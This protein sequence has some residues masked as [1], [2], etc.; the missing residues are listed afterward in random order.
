MKRQRSSADKVAKSGVRIWWAGW[1]GGA[2]GSTGAPAGRAEGSASDAPWRRTIRTRVVVMLVGAAV[3]VV[4]IEA[5]LVQL[6][7][8]EHDFYAGRADR[9]QQSVIKTPADRGDIVDRD[10]QLLA[11]TV[12]G[13]GLE[14]NPR[15]VEDPVATA[16]AI[17]AALEDCSPDDRQTMVARLSRDAG[18]VPLR[19]VR[20][21]SQRQAQR[22]ADLGL[23]GVYLTPAPHRF[24]PN[25][26]L[27]AHLIGFVGAE[28]KGLSGIEQV[29]DDEIRGEDGRTILQVDARSNR[30]AT[31]VQRD[32]TAGATLELTIDQY[33][34]Y[35]AE[36][37]LQEAVIANDAAGATAIVMSVDTGEI[38]AMANVPTFNPNEYGQYSSATW[39]N[40]AL[41]EI[42]E[43]GSTF[44]LVTAA[45]AIEE[46][47]FSPDALIDTSP[48]SIRLPGRSTPVSDTH[49]YGLLT[50]EDVI[51][52]SSNVGAIKIGLQIGAERLIRS[53]RRLGFGQTLAPD[54]AGESAGLIKRPEAL[55][56]SSLGSMSMGYEIGVTPLQMVTAVSS[57]ANGGDLYQPHIVRAIVRDGVR[58]AVEP[59]VLRRTVSP[60]T[61]AILTTMMEGVVERGTATRAQIEGYR[62]AGKTGTSQKAIDGG[63]SKTDYNASFVG[64]VPSRNPV[65]AILVVVDT[66]RAGTYYGGSV[67]A[68]VFQRIADAAL[69]H[70]GVPPTVDPAPPVRRVRST[71][72]APAPQLSPA[73]PAVVPVRTGLTGDRHQVPD[74]RG[75]PMRDAVR[76]MSRAGL[77]VRVTGSGVVV[78]QEP[79][80]GTAISSDAWSLLRLQ[81]PPVAD[82]PARP[83]RGPTGAPE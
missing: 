69:R 75:L 24:Y 61:A 74:V 73:G 5:R 27:A 17:C 52:K 25:F 10:G 39:R 8:L 50:F 48:G 49:S 44:K 15:L 9:Q 54:F 71:E 18:G 32:P 21:M 58:E 80:A 29:Y 55:S 81:A 76:E 63:Y 68:P 36:R 33:L 20:Q 51:V 34:Q 23:D 16:A 6:Q 11:Y 31:L 30:L 42:Y 66:P 14:A 77:S 46:G 70:V 19:S 83:S 64:F 79:A 38:L 45:A 7:V 12:E 60:R 26:E 62:V 22:V 28:N 57:I 72:P 67:A 37:E 82:A 3:W 56:V 78:S 2:R 53:A 65:F 40:R 47:V 13:H 1:R 4:G 41:Q 43:P 59:T 35:T